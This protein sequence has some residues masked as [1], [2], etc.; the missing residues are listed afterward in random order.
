MC[1]YVIYTRNVKLTCYFDLNPIMYYLYILFKSR[2]SKTLITRRT[3]KLK[4]SNKQY[5]VSMDKDFRLG[6]ISY[7]NLKIMPQLIKSFIIY[8]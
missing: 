7:T 2:I 1:T 5:Q 4:E 3:N 8:G 6:F